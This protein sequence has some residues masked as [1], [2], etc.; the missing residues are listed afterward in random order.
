MSDTFMFWSADVLGKPAWAWALFIGIVGA[1]LAFD[2]GRA[3]PQA[4]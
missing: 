4:A 2:P 3:A 1:L